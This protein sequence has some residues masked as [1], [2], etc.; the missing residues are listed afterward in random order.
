MG[1]KAGGLT[2]GCP[3]DKEGRGL[4]WEHLVL[5]T[6]RVFV[7]ENSLYYWRDKSG[8]E[9]DFVIR[10]R[11]R[12]TDTME[13][14][15]NPDR[16]DPA[17]LVIFRSLY[18]VGNNYVICPHVKTPYVKRFGKLTVNFIPIDHVSKMKAE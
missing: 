7:D 15:I 14:K 17:N 4:L 12:Q 9:I 10:R 16:F 6:L 2:P 11:N 3:T 8:R 13:C 1:K 5:D 18:P